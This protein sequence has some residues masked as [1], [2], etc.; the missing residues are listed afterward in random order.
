MDKEGADGD[1]YAE[2]NAD[3]AEGRC[4]VRHADQGGDNRREDHGA[5]S[6]Y[7]GGNAADEAALI[8]KILDAA[9]D[10]AAIGHAQAQTG[11]QTVGD[12]Q[13]TDAGGEAGEKHTCGK[14]Q[15]AHQNDLVRAE[16]VIEPAAGD[17][18]DGAH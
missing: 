16:A 11:Q 1:D 2:Y 3:I 4:G 10:G 7:G 13:K 14:H 5:L 12:D 18:G 9:A 15:S 17:H 6:V 8:R